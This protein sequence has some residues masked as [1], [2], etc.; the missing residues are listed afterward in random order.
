VDAAGVDLTALR[1]N[2][3]RKYASVVP[4]A[5][6]VV[7]WEDAEY[8]PDKGST[9]DEYLDPTLSDEGSCEQSEAR[10]EAYA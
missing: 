4:D 9:G 7:A 2:A 6:I 8:V 10:E 3:R 5:E 1:K